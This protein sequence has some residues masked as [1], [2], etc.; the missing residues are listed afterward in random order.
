MSQELELSLF[1][2]AGGGVLGSQLLGWK[3]IGY[4]EYADYPARVLA[5]RIKDGLIDEAP[6]FSDIRTF[7]NDGYAEAYKGVVT[8]L[9]G[10]FPCQPFSVAGQRAGES[11]SRNLFP[12]VADCIS[13]IKPPVVYLEN[14]PGLLSAGGGGVED[15]TGRSVCGYFGHI[16]RTIHELGYDAKWGVVGSDD[17]SVWTVHR[18]KRLWILAHARP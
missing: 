11:D 2:G 15:S 8:I 13:I 16:L 10:G 17:S 1:S 7:I 4:C 14:V 9:S 18:R 5:Q 3:T 12:S 6:I